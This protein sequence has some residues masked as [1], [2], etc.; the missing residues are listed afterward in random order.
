MAWV[1]G[2]ARM[3]RVNGIWLSGESRVEGLEEVGLQA[4]A[5]PSKSPLNWGS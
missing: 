5:T 2:L 3:L 4:S 1:V